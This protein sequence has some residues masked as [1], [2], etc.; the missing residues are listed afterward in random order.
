MLYTPRAELS[1]THGDIYD[2]NSHYY[3]FD[4]LRRS[5]H[6]AIAITLIRKK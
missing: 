5:V 4:I 1:T 3:I 6:Y 2:Y